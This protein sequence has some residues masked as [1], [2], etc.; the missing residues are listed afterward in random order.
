MLGA[1]LIRD[2]VVQQSQ[3]IDACVLAPVL[4]VKPFHHKELAVNRVLRV[5]QHC[6]THRHLRIIEHR[7]PSRFLVLEPL[8]HPITIGLAC[9]TADRGGKVTSLLAQGNHPQIFALATAKEQG[10]A[11]MAESLAHLR[12]DRLA[13][14][15]Q[16]HHRMKPAGAQPGFGKQ[17]PQAVAGAFEAIGEHALDLRGGIMLEG[18]LTQGAIGLLKSSGT[19]IPALAHMPDHAAPDHRGQVH[20]GGQAMAVLFI[21]QNIHWQGQPTAGQDRHEV[22]AAHGTDQARDGH[23]RDVADHGTPFQTQPPHALPTRRL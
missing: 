15:R 10:G 11:L 16:F 5:V 23:W 14:P 6:A 22:L 20:L 8:S 2:Q 9:L 21:G 4:M 17:T 3:T 19:L 7:I 13:F 1:P 18:C 12:R